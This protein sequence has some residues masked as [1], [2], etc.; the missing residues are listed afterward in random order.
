[1]TPIFAVMLCI[2]VTGSGGQ[3]TFSGCKLRPHAPLF[4]SVEACK[5]FINRDYFPEREGVIRY[6][7]ECATKSVSTWQPAQ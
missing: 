7:S 4:N 6:T 2:Y 3:E 5:D 1:M